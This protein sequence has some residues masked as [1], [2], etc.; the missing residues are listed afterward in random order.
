[1]LTTPIA[2]NMQTPKRVS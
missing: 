1:L 2:V